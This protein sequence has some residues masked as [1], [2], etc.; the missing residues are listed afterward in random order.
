MSPRLLDSLWDPRGPRGAGARLLAGALTVPELLFRG[1]VAARELL[2]RGGIL[3]VGRAPVPVI[4]V[5]GIEVGGTGKTPLTLELVRLAALAGLRAAVA[6]RGYGARSPGS[7]AG[8]H[9]VWKVPDPPAPDAAVRFGDEAVWLA[10]RTGLAGGA[11]VWVAPCRILA[12]RAAAAAGARLVLLDDGLQHRRLHR[13]GEVVTLLGNAPMG[14]GRLLPRGPLR[15][16][17]KTALARA[18]VA[19][20]AGINPSAVAKGAALIRPLLRAGVPIFSWHGEPALVP[21]AGAAPAPGEPV[22][23][24]AAIAHPERLAETME[25]LG[26][27]P[28]ATRLFRDHHRFS[29]SDLVGL[30]GVGETG[31]RGVLLTTE[32]DWPRLRGVLPPGSRVALIV[33]SLRWNEPDAEPWWIDWL[34][35][36][37]TITA[38]TAG[39][40][41]AA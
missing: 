11:G 1:G 29:E 17:P 14:N 30:S 39:S 15:E 22:A 34:R 10:S 4:S 41:G 12:A 23:L 36:A 27:T 6:T 8:G 20:L 37:T 21:V 9:A 18:D 32:K 3:P 40:A 16:P 28:A 26:L 19:V 5:G 35:A 33:Q 24:L 13:D 2:L 31:A 25:R 38:A 7:R